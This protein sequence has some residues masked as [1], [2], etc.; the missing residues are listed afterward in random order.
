[1]QISEKVMKLGTESAFEVLTRAEHL[2][3]QGRDII[4]LGIGQPDFL[5]AEHIVEAAVKALKDGFHG[6]TPAQ[7]IESLR[8]AVSEQYHYRYGLSVNPNNVLITPGGKPVIFFVASFF[9]DKNAEILYP[10]PGFPIYRSVIDFSGA[11]GVSYPIL[12]E[13]NFSINAELVLDKISSKTRLLILNSPHNPTGSVSQKKELE[14]LVEGLLEYPDVAILSDEI[15]SQMYFDN[16]THTSMIQFPEIQNRLITLDGWSKTY[17]MTG[18]RLGYS[19]WPDRLIERATRFA[20]NTHSCVNGFVQMA[21]I[22][23][24]RGPQE[25][26]SEMMM[27]FE[28]RRN[29]LVAKLNSIDKLSC[30]NPLGAFY[31][32]PN[33]RK[34]GKDSIEL[35]HELL[36]NTGVATIAG[37]SFGSFGEGY[38]RISFANSYE[39]IKDAANR[40]E[41]Y[42]SG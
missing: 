28:K 4:N 42:L 1:M 21:G 32:F 40:I 36:E 25:S 14:K 3:K 33:I 12:E 30:T 37:A 20:I 6:Y 15:Y 19:I 5:T 2:K 8:E 9:G 34:T 24:L 38:I 23:A 29:F 7:G 11:K 39:R 16:L 26:L 13:Y 41:A 22:A 31:A 17:A 35:Q 10:N 27:A 18:W